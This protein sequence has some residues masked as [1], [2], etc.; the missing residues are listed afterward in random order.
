M[1]PPFLFKT[2]LD[3]PAD[4]SAVTAHLK[5]AEF[6]FTGG[7]V[8]N[9]TDNTARVQAFSADRIGSVDAIISD[10]YIKRTNLNTEQLYVLSG[11]GSS[12]DEHKQMD[13]CVAT[14]SLMMWDGNP[15]LV[16][17]ATSD[18][19]TLPGES[20]FKYNGLT[21]TTSLQMPHKQPDIALFDHDGHRRYYPVK[22]IKRRI[23]HYIYII[24]RNVSR[25]FRDDALSLSLFRL[26]PN[27]GTIPEILL[28]EVFRN[29]LKYPDRIC[30]RILGTS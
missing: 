28:L 14:G 1:P 27:G 21:D 22:E 10:E 30:L 2:P 18:L 17:S 24:F 7:I 4:E 12:S 29:H 9:V 26:V 11:K 15:Q 25:T 13:W 20:S 8:S 16:S 3:S 5:L 6:T 19:P 23:Y